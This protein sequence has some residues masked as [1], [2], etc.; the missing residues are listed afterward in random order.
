M[1]IKI[2]VLLIL[3][4]TAIM[5]LTLKKSNIRNNKPKN[6][7]KHKKVKQNK[8]ATSF[9]Q[10]SQDTN[11]AFDDDLATEDSYDSSTGLKKPYRDYNMAF[12]KSSDELMKNVKEDLTGEEINYDFDE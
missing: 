8:K 5:T 4:L 9:L 12:E 2:L 6:R 1:K 11:S 7:K 10:F 3:C